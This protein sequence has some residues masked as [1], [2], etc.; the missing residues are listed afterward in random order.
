MLIALL[1]M[2]VVPLAAGVYLLRSSASGNTSRSV[3]SI[4]DF[5]RGLL[6]WFVVRDADVPVGSDPTPVT[7]SIKQGETVRDIARRLQEAGLIRDAESFRTLLRVEGVDRAVEA[8]EYKLRRNMT[9]REIM[10]VLQK[11]LPPTVTVTIPEGKR[12]EEIV[13]LIAAQGLAKRDELLNLIQSGG[14]FNYSF[15]ADRPKDRRTL[16]GYLFPDTYEFRRDASAH[17]IIDAML[18]NFD[19]RFTLEMRQAATRIGLNIDQVVILAGI[20]EREAV[21]ASE[22]PIIASVYLNRLR[23]GMKLDADPTIQYAMGFDPATKTWW[24]TLNVGDLQF[25]S[26][27]NTYLSPGLPPGPICNPGLASLQAVVEAA[28]TDYLYFVA[29]TLAGDGTHVFASTWEEHL[30]NVARYR[31]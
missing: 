4:D 8:G 11:G 30:Q 23:Q 18:Q 24:R 17:D 13:D 7:F 19:R 25:K 12:A 2:L 16:E 20:V 3:I 21:Q 15:L 6:A 22:R 14:D 26:P 27:Y 9:P 10:T 31:P 5:G 29:N 28:Q 1:G